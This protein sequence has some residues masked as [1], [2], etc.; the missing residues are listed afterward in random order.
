MRI[1][2]LLSHLLLA[3]SLMSKGNEEERGSAGLSRGG[4][5]SSL[6]GALKRSKRNTKAVYEAES[7]IQ[8]DSEAQAEEMSQTQKNEKEVQRHE[9]VSSDNPPPYEPSD[10]VKASAP[11]YSDPSPEEQKIENIAPDNENDAAE[12]PNVDKT[13]TPDSSN[14]SDT[15]E[16]GPSGWLWVGLPSLITAIVIAVVCWYVLTLLWRLIALGSGLLII[17]VFFLVWHSKATSIE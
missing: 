6:K 3:W 10:P 1:A 9:P 13:S 17:L 15:N 12:T 14:Q 16:D 4:I 11:T 7:N 8:D 5:I 2:F